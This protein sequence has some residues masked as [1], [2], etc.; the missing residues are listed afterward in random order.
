MG[1]RLG[2]H[3]FDTAMGS[4]TALVVSPEA[5]VRVGRERLEALRRDHEGGAI[6]EAV[7]R[8][9]SEHSGEDLLVVFRGRSADGQGSWGFAEDLTDEEAGELGYH[10]VVDQLP[11][12]RRLVRAGVFALVHT[13]W[14]VREAEA[15]RAGTKQLL[16]ELESQAVPEVEASTEEVA[17][18]NA[19]RYILR[20]LT[21]FHDAPFDAVVR[22]VIIA[23]LESFEAQIPHFRELIRDVPLSAPTAV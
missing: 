13:E 10:L 5:H 9:V 4:R 3:R 17:V 1:V 20:N 14:G 7:L 8:L 12:Y 19:D 18:S 22:S 15:Y 16:E 2:E 6:D 21:H 11:T 23:H